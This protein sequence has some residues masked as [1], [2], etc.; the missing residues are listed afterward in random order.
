MKQKIILTIL[1]LFIATNSAFADKLHCPDH[2]GDDEKARKIARRYFK[3]GNGFHTQ[4]DI[5]KFMEAFECVLKLVPYSHSARYKYA[6]ALDEAKQYSKARKQYKLFLNTTPETANIKDLNKIKAQ[7]KKR[8][9][10]IAHLKD[11]PLSNNEKEKK[12]TREF[13]K[14]LESLKKE[15][16]KKKNEALVK[17]NAQKE[18]IEN[19]EKE[20]ARLLAKYVKLKQE[21]IEKLEEKIN[22]DGNTEGTNLKDKQDDKPSPTKPRYKTK[23]N[24]LRKWGISVMGVGILSTI[25]A[26]GAGSYRYIAKTEAENKSKDDYDWLTEEDTNSEVTTWKT[27]NS[28]EAKPAYENFQTSTTIVTVSLISSAVLLGTGAMLYFLG[29]EEKIEINKSIDNTPVDKSK[30]SFNFSPIINQNSMGISLSFKY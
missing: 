11:K 8:L 19:Y 16:K 2:P 9:T 7:I 17:L 24:S 22:N 5:I 20:K 21:K 14:R 29:D 18:R 1:S 30:S 23:M 3:M 12:E 6:Q 26:V 10:E 27:W 15:H 13:N 25:V 28:S 4:G